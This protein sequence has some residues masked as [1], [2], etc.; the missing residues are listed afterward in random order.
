[1]SPL[2][3]TVAAR[4]PLVPALTNR[5]QAPCVEIFATKALALPFSFILKWSLK[6]F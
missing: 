5:F 1:M 6:K 2:T 4:S 3:V